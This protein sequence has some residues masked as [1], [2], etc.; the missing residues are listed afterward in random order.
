MANPFRPDDRLSVWVVWDGARIVAS[1]AAWP[2]PVWLDGR[3]RLGWWV[4]DLHVLPPYRG[5][6]LARALFDAMAPCYELQMLIWMAPATRHLALSLGWR[7]AA[8]VAHFLKHL[9]VRWPAVVRRLA[10][11]RAHAVLARLGAAGELVAAAGSA[12]AFGLPD[13]RRLA[14]TP[15]AG[16]HLESVARFDARFDELWE[17]AAPALPAAVV[18]DV[19]YL[20]WKFVDAPDVPYRRLAAVRAERALGFV[21]FHPR[22]HVDDAEGVI[23]DLLVADDEPPVARVLVAAAVRALA[24]EGMERVVFD[25]TSASHGAALRALGFKRT[26]AIPFCVRDAAGAGAGP[27]HLTKGDGDFDQVAGAASG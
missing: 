18:R 25:T 26:H 11:R 16:V 12:L 23:A 8:Q 3:R 1:V 14:L 27:W 20:N 17:R 19:R 22:G 9:R 5:R 6:G 24:Q 21:V 13:R 10:P 7:E 2:V 4:S 15:P